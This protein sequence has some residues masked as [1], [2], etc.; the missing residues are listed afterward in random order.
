[1]WS[2]E[3]FGAI[4][5]ESRKTYLKQHN[6]LFFRFL[7]PWISR[8]CTIGWDEK[9]FEKISE[10][11][12]SEIFKRQIWEMRLFGVDSLFNIRGVK[13]QNF[14]TSCPFVQVLP[15]PFVLLKT[16]PLPDVSG[17]HFLDLCDVFIYK[18]K[19]TRNEK[20]K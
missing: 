10:M 7:Q 9:I 16:S 18:I 1:M 8:H 13:I 5:E 19:L 4:L 17:L 2:V 15:Y 14:Q 20:E 12:L 6:L 11:S 3:L